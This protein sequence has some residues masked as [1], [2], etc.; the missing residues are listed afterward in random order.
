MID[1]DELTAALRG[2]L[3]ERPEVELALLFGSRARG[4]ARAASD[5]DVAVE[6]ENVDRLALARD[7]SAAAGLEVEVV[8]LRR[9]GY[10]LLKALLRDGVVLHQG[11]PHAEAEFRTRAILQ[12]E[13]DRPWYE[14]MRDGYLHHLAEAADGRS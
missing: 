11:R 13:T 10:P 8:D 6:G 7:L 1:R 4:L 14:R 9:A 3:V 5:V 12:T 2:V